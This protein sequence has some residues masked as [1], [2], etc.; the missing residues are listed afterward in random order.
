I[1]LHQS[2]QTVM[3]LAEVHR[4][5][6]HEDAHPV[7]REDHSADA[8]AAAIAPIRFAGVPDDRR[9]VTS[10]TAISIQSS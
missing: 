3:A 5:R 2:R 7:R 8:S 6:R 10:P 1:T 4:L 9:T